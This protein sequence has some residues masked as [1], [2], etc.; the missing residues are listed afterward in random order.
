MST[1]GGVRKYPMKKRL[2]IWTLLGTG[3]AALAAATGVSADPEKGKIFGDWIIA[4][5]ETQTERNS[6][7]FARQV[8]V[9]EN[10]EGAGDGRSRRLI[11]MRVG[12][13]GPNGEPAV[14]ALLPLGIYIPAGVALRIDDANPIPLRLEFCTRMGCRAVK[15]LDQ[16]QLFALQMS[17]ELSIRF[18]PRL[19][20]KLASIR[21]SPKG[22]FKAVE[23]LK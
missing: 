6:Q 10:Q 15:I 12:F 22:L 16:D 5:T 13:L 2:I 1:E 14:V 4:C 8:Q 20:G 21:L 9:T 23:S 7:C 18:S 3:I 11:D 17:N 19:S